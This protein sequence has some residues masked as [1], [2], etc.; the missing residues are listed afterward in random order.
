ML[1]KGFHI[2]PASDHRNL[3]AKVQA[4]LLVYATVASLFLPDSVLEKESLEIKRILYSLCANMYININP[5]LLC[6]K[7]SSGSVVRVSD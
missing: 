3:S 5:T 7:R 1:G 2:S 4:T 6:H